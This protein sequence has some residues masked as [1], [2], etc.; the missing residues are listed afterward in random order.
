MGNNKNKKVPKKRK[1]TSTSSDQKENVPK[2]EKKRVN[3]PN[4]DDGIAMSK[5]LLSKK[6]NLRAQRQSSSKPERTCR[7]GKPSPSLSE[8]ERKYADSDEDD[9]TPKTPS[10]KPPPSE[11]NL[12]PATINK[13]TER[14]LSSIQEQKLPDP[15]EVMEATLLFREKSPPP[16]PIIPPKKV[17]KSNIPY[18]VGCKDRPKVVKKGNTNFCKG[19][20]EYGVEAS[21]EDPEEQ[22]PAKRAKRSK[23]PKYSKSIFNAH[24]DEIANRLGNDDAGEVSD[25]SSDSNKTIE[26]EPIIV[27]NSRPQSFSPLPSTSRDKETFQKNDELFNNSLQE[28]QITKDIFKKNDEQTDESLKEINTAKD[29]TATENGDTQMINTSTPIKKDDDVQIIDIP[30]ETIVIDDIYERKAGNEKPSYTIDNSVIEIIETPGSKVDKLEI[31]QIP[32]DED[33]MIVPNSGTKENQNNLDEPIVIDDEYS[34]IDI[35]FDSYNSEPIEII[36]VDDVIAENKS[37]LEKWKNSQ[38]L[39]KINTIVDVPTTYR[40]VAAVTTTVTS[41]TVQTTSSQS[42]SLQAKYTPTTS[43]QACIESDTA[44]QAHL[45]PSITLQANVPQRT[46]LQANVPQ[47]TADATTS[48]ANPVITN[49]NDARNSKRNDWQKKAA[50][51][52][53]AFTRILDDFF[54]NRRATSNPSSTS[55]NIDRDTTRF[56]N[57]IVNSFPSSRAEKVS[58]PRNNCVNVSANTPQNWVSIPRIDLS[59]SSSNSETNSTVIPPPSPIPQRNIGDCPIC[60]D[61]LNSCNGIASTI[62][63]HV[64]CLKCIQASIKSSGK[65]CPTCRK[66]LKGVGY[67][68]LYL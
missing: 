13:I 64:F 9:E 42:T 65:K 29:L 19:D 22:L 66:G 4:P 20:E 33:C 61:P 35:D 21:S 47:S 36:D 23:I 53:I 62:C 45:T 59:K 8:L 11:N 26:Y 31:M 58:Q 16:P 41:T 57:T 2:T 49:R 50:D 52:S 54:A 6:K 7:I 3:K 44:L 12:S 38:E 27:Q 40:N 25:A 28:S 5:Q 63:G 34:T 30:Y 37:I 24:S 55:M 60:L 68:Q 32:N 39:N 15:S 48:T 18:I 43:L 67:H 10:K 17:K 51:I 56:V 46:T 14:L 1:A